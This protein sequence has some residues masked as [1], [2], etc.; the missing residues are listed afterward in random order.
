[1]YTDDPG[2]Q[3]P[4]RGLAG[5]SVE[6]PIGPDLRHHLEPPRDELAQDLTRLDGIALQQRLPL[7]KERLELAGQ[8][9]GV[10]RAGRCGQPVQVFELGL[11]LA[12]PALQGA[13]LVTDRGQGAE[14]PDGIREAP[15]LRGDLAQPSAERLSLGRQFLRV[16]AFEF[17]RPA[18]HGVDHVGGKHVTLER[19]EHVGIQ[20]AHGR[21]E[22]VA[23]E[24]IAAHAVSQPVLVDVTAEDTTDL[25]IAAL[26]QG[27][28][29]VLANKKPLAGTAASH[30]R[31]L[32]A[33][34]AVARRVRYEATVGAGLPILDTFRKLVE[35]GD[36][37]LRVE[38]CVSGTLGFVL[39]AVS[40]G[41]AFSAAVREAVE[42]GYAEP[43]PREDLSGRD[44]ARKG[45]ILARLLGYRGASPEPEGLVPAALRRVPLSVFL[46]KLERLDEAWRVRVA[47]AAARGR[48]LRYVVT[49][50]RGSVA[51]RLLAVPATSPIGA[52]TGTRNLISFTSRRY[53]SEPLV[54]TGPGAG[55]DVTAAGLLNDI[56][57]LARAH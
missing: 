30:R 7:P 32:E 27:F 24:E 51:A 44:A 37:V 40:Q 45:L 28:D 38:G 8:S 41:R 35:S 23:A 14:L 33:A 10:P 20:V 42:C 18:H 43:D 3:P 1:L 12:P 56:Q 36:R 48:V 5:P 4:I 54:I 22:T 31:L 53:S 9:V 52:L 34:A 57:F 21:R 50:T 46:V 2:Q 11:R 29:L 6:T 15:N 16:H 49:A 25:L 17:D 47:R 39:S 55:A 19:C 13:Q 26:G